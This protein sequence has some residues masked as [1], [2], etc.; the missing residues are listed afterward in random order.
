MALP[1]LLPLWIA[2]AGQPQPS[3]AQFYLIAEAPA[4]T[5]TPAT[6]FT[7]LAGC[8]G[9]H[10][11]VDGQMVFITAQ[12]CQQAGAIYVVFE[13]YRGNFKKEGDKNTAWLPIKRFQPATAELAGDLAYR[14]LASGDV[15][16][17]V[18][19]LSQ[20]R[21]LPKLGASVQV[22]GFPMANGPIKLNCTF[23]GH[24]GGRMAFTQGEGARLQ[25][26][27]SCNPRTGIPIEHYVGFSGG[28]V[29]DVDG[30]FLG[31]VS[32]GA[33]LDGK[34]LV[35][36]TNATQQTLN[37]DGITSKVTYRNE[38]SDGRHVVPVQINTSSQQ[39]L[40]FGMKKG[41]LDGAYMLLDANGKPEEGHLFS[42][43]FKIK[44]VK[45]P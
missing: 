20:A 4:G 28:P 9:S 17:Q 44:V 31:A 21:S 12:H 34:V 40:S 24:L 2:L 45:G 27:A 22:E 41:L 11:M 7:P 10:V 18:R 29:T 42:H 15:S 14:A 19:R 30:K 32:S 6:K 36:F 5:L 25:A 3:P 38:F 43:G 13:N 23:A 37:V 39:R 16:T 26:I 35:F 33:T 8:A 1:T